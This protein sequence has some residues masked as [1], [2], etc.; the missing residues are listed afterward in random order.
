MTAAILTSIGIAALA[1]TA[2]MFL[3]LWV[4]P[5]IR[6]HFGPR[7]T[8]ALWAIVP[9]ATLVSLLPSRE[10]V[11]V[12]TLAPAPQTTVSERAVES[13]QLAPSGPIDFV[14]A[15]TSHA[16]AFSMPDIARI[17]LAVWAIGALFMLARLVYRQRSFMKAHTVGDAA[18][19]VAKTQNVGPV[20]A[21]IFKS[22]IIVPVDFKT[23]YT[24]LERKLIVAHER[25]H[26]KAGDM[27]FNLIAALIDC[28]FWFNPLIK[29]AIQRFKMDQEL[30]CDARVMKRFG[31]HRRAY[32]EAL[33]K[34]QFTGDTAPLACAWSSKALKARLEGLSETAPGPLKNMLG[35]LVAALMISGAAAAAWAAFPEE[36]TVYKS[37]DVVDQDDLT[38]E[39]KAEIKEQVTALKRELREAEKMLAEAK[40]VEAKKREVERAAAIIERMEEIEHA[41]A[42]T[43][44]VRA[45][46]NY[47]RAQAAG[48][49]AKLASMTAQ[50]RAY[51]NL[52]DQDLEDA[53]EREVEARI[54]DLKA[55]LKEVKLQFKELELSRR[56]LR[57]AYKNAR[58]AAEAVDRQAREQDRQ[59]GKQVQMNSEEKRE[60]TDKLTAELAVLTIEARAAERLLFEDLDNKENDS[61]I[62][63]I[64]QRIGRFSQKLEELDLDEAE[65]KNMQEMALR[66][67]EEYERSKIEVKAAGLEVPSKNLDQD[68]S[69]NFAFSGDSE[70]LVLTEAKGNSEAL[71]MSA[72]STGGVTR[73]KTSAGNESSSWLS[74]LFSSDDDGDPAS[75]ALGSAL[76]RAAGRGNM[77]DV[78]GLIESGADV[79]YL[80]RGDGTPLLMAARRGHTNV[81]KTL[82]DAGADPDT[83]APGDGNALLVAAGRGHKNIV[84]L[85]LEAGADPNAAAPGDGNA[86]ITAARRGHEHI[87]EL[88]LQ[89]GAD[90]NAYVK[91]DE[92]PL[93]GA[94]AAG[95][96]SIARLLIEAGADVNLA[97]DSGNFGFLKEDLRSPVG[98][99]KRFGNDRMVKL[100]LD[101]GAEDVPAED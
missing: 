12:E 90:P 81:L 37:T 32:G 60:L 25:A 31:A 74:N 7:V 14:P 23:R 70:P 51:E 33:L 9:V 18:L 46:E 101:A 79:D 55:N 8:Y 67:A 27:R 56:E 62:R 93:I 43:S 3:V 42:L 87:A 22:H 38:D 6:R 30:A 58:R 16:P 72:T 96:N 86:L 21:G 83:Y 85:L 66:A 88:L 39:Q 47:K 15:T 80:E 82:L 89:N 28:L 69:Y 5:T 71:V 91:G 54:K 4:R 24:V 95:Y 63:N 59:A 44:E 49:K 35:G 98:Q 76:V 61:K 68:S 78:R 100:L 99:A 19:Q 64:D 50:L 34:T 1:A 20:A 2:A 77:R 13:A 94:A 75:E 48:L 84:S 73:V 40:G 11:T 52:L 53:Q 29:F 10:I 41:R 97:V 92:T 65:I 17:L 57:E 26:I 45:N 36:R